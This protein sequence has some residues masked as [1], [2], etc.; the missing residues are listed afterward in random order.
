MRLEAIP[1]I[2]VYGPRD[3][4]HRTSLVAF[5]VAG[6]DPLALAQALNVAGVEARAGCHCVPLAHHALGIEASCR[7]SFYLYNTFDEV[8]R[9][10]DALAEIV[11]FGSDASKQHLELEGT[12]KA[13]IARPLQPDPRGSLS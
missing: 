5:N 3:A 7:F 6:H 8:D 1:G 13:S 10:V 9:A 2:T 12:G 11:S 4:S